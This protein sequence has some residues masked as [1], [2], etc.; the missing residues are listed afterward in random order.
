MINVKIFLSLFSTF[1]FLFSSC[2]KD[3]DLQK[4][5]TPSFTAKINGIPFT[6]TTNYCTLY[7]DSALQFRAFVL[8]GYYLDKILAITYMD[9]VLTEVVTINTPM[10]GLGI[11][12]SYEDPIFTN[13]NTQISSLL[14][15]TKFDT[16]INITN[17]ILSGTVVGPTTQD[18]LYITNGELRN[19]PYLFEYSN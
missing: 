2:K 18:T 19:I 15:F 1:L 7:V 5:S 11:N 10:T 16:L 12:L 13:V 6:A 3:G 17:G 9:T 14:I 4:D 8:T